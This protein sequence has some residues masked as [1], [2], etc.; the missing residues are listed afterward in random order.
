MRRVSPEAGRI[1]AI[2]TVLPARPDVSLAILEDGI[3]LICKRPFT[4]LPRD[5]P[6][7]NHARKAVSRGDPQ[8]PLTVFVRRENDPV[9]QAIAYAESRNPLPVHA[10]QPLARPGPDAALLVLADEFQRIGCRSQADIEVGDDALP[11]QAA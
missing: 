11:V 8:L 6:P 7:L 10:V 9:R 2:Q 5:E 3:N 1:E 4:N